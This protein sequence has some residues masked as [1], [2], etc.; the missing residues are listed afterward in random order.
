MQ[1]CDKITTYVIYIGFGTEQS[2]HPVP[3]ATNLTH[4]YVA[5]LPIYF[6]FA[7]TYGTGDKIL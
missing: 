6:P 4:P 2:Q 3:I 1:K 7:Y 5:K